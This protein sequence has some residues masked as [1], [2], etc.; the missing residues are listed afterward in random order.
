LEEGWGDLIDEFLEEF[1]RDAITSRRFALQHHGNGISDFFQSEFFGQF[2]IRF[3]QTR[4]GVLAQHVSRAS[5][6]PGALASEV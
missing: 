1:G 6:V 4:V 5:E 2:L 3:D